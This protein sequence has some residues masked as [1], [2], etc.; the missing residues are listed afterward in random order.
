MAKSDIELENAKSK[1]NSEDSLLV[2]YILSVL[3]KY[4]SPEAPISTQAVMDY[5]NQDY[6]IGVTDKN[7]AQKKKVR[8]HLE[9]LHECYG[10]G[11]I[12][13][14]EGKTRK[15]H[16]WYY[17]AT[18]DQCASE[19]TQT[20]ET[21]S[22][23]E[24]EF[25]ID[26]I[27]ATQ[28]LNS[29]SSLGMLDKLLKKTSLTEEEREQRI[30]AIKKEG[31]LKN[32]NDDLVEKKEIIESYFDVSRI[33]FNYEGN[34]SVLAT[35]CGWIYSNGKCFLQ[36]KVGGQSR[37]FLLEK[38]HDIEEADGYEDEEEYE[39]D[40]EDDLSNN[41]SLESL[42]SNIPF[43]KSAI[44]DK[45]GI[46][47]DYRS[48]VVKNN[49]VVFEENPKNVLPHS[50]VFN[51]GKYYLIGIDE[52]A[53][54]TNKIGY[55]RVD[56]IVDLDYSSRKITL[57]DWNK[58]VYDTIQRA[59]EVEKHPLMVAGQETVVDFLVIES[60]LDRVRDAFGTSP[61]FKVTKETKLVPIDS[62]K[63]RWNEN[64][65][66]SEL[67]R[68]NLVRFTVKT[69]RDEA[70]RWALANADAVEL[71]YPPDLRHKLRRIAQPIHRTYVKTM[72][73]KV[74]A[75]VEHI[76]ASGT[77]KI[78]QRINEEL[79][80]ETFKV[81][82]NEETRHSNQYLFSTLIKCGECGWSF[83]RSERT[84]KNTYVRWVCSDR[85]GHGT[86]SCKN[87]VSIDEND[88]IEAI[89]S[90]FDSILSNKEKYLCDAKKIFL[91]NHHQHTDAEQ[92]KEEITKKLAELNKQKQKNM[93][94]FSRDL[95]SI[96]ELEQ[97]VQPIKAEIARLEFELRQYSVIFDQKVFDQSVD[98]VFRDIQNITDIRK[99]SNAQLKKIIKEIKVF[100]DGRIKIYLN[101]LT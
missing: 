43:I 81:L 38:I 21:L 94:M 86:E 76:F 63:Q 88:L 48:Y 60:A 10:N 9:T 41:T 24:L 15:G 3:K 7:E 100:K 78:D 99:L 26:L 11:C 52:N 77:F 34:S 35:P 66:L 18:R 67:P 4:S 20:R 40:Y 71:V 61:I 46:K 29:E 73:D 51:D 80:F 39:Y 62:S 28:L 2:I 22:D 1:G 72:S 49:R 98:S 55:F 6:S 27:S 101:H 47:F 33:R 54:E 16:D 31:W 82:S 95:I 85:N 37:Q 25:I 64:H 14:I 91:E 59:R 53:P 68:E 12:A 96:E 89:Q 57:S 5:L 44:K 69:T 75:N 45:K 65:S 90:H 58:Q 19:E 74:Q 93:M 84:Y 32:P 79:A 87:A 17:N 30:K 42:F 70:F 23:V 8:R 83:R 92:K 97:L 13:K 56:L 50:L 36:A